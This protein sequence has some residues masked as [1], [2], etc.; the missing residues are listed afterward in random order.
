VLFLSNNLFLT[1]W[2]TGAGS[3]LLAKQHS[4]M[5]QAAKIF[6]P[7]A[8]SSF[9]AMEMIQCPSISR[10]NTQHEPLIA[11]TLLRPGVVF[12][13]GVVFGNIWVQKSQWIFRNV[14]S[15]H[16]FV[17]ANDI[18]ESN[19]RELL[20]GVWFYWVEL[21]LYRWEN[22]LLLELVLPGQPSVSWWHLN[23]ISY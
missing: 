11:L 3:Q 22:K 2:S 20:L 15:C 8:A 9:Y 23:F 1:Y 12:A 6:S 17:V 16:H 4:S 18:R 14:F 19:S 7:T 21:G 5:G 10:T 13:K